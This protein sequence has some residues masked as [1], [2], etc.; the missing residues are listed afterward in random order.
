MSL[1]YE[2]YNS[3]KRTRDFLRDLMDA[4]A[5]PKTV[6][7]TRERAYRCLRHFPFLYENGKPMFSRDPF[8]PP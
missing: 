8:S 6:R 4:K 1:R 7:E 2:Q 3:L 5:R